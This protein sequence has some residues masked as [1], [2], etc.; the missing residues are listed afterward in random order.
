MF[1][2]GQCVAGRL[3]SLFGGFAMPKTDDPCMVF[4]VIGEYETMWPMTWNDECG[5]AIVVDNN[6]PPV[7]FANPAAA[8][9]AITISKRFEQLRRAQ[10]RPHNSDFL[11]DLKQVKI[12]RVQRGSTSP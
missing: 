7:V 5:G 8:R 2:G 12:V 3:S 9:A 10:G 6:K 11:E 1:N 4:F